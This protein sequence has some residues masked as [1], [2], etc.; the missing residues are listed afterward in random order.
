MICE[1]ENKAA[2][3]IF[4]QAFELTDEEKEAI[5]R[6]RIAI[7]TRQNE[8]SPSL[9]ENWS[10]SQRMRFTNEWA[11]YHGLCQESD[12]PSEVIE[13]QT[14]EGKRPANDDTIESPAKRHNAEE[15]FTVKSVKQVNIRKFCTTGTD[16]NLI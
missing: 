13:S 1:C 8:V 7:W 9:I 12:A 3:N 5:S 2:L 15:Y 10:A 11:N 6:R 14:G 16:F 4:E